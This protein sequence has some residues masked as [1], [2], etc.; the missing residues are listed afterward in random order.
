ML[1]KKYETYTFSEYKE[2]KDLSTIDKLIGNLKKNKKE[3][4]NLVCLLAI[5]IPK[6]VFAQT[7][8]IGLGDTGFEIVHLLL[9]FAKYGC[10][11]MGV[12][13]MVEEMLQGANIKEATG[14]GIQYFIF[15]I[16]LNLYPKLFDKIK[17]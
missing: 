17:F 8:D 4:A 9:K 5:T 10:M 14:A 2:L 1:L 7:N 3:Y 15:Y 6:Q 16:I 12:K 11:A 13:N